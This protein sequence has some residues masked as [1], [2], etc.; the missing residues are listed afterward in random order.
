M[1]RKPK[2]HKG[3]ICRNCDYPLNGEENFGKVSKDY[4]QGKRKRYMNPFQLFL[5]ASIVFFLVLGLINMIETYNNLAVSSEDKEFSNA[6]GLDN[7]VSDD[8]DSFKRTYVMQLD[9]VFEQIKQN[10]EDSLIVIHKEDSIYNRLLMM[11]VNS[12]LPQLDSLEGSEGVADLDISQM[13]SNAVKAGNAQKILDDYLK[14]NNYLVKENV[15]Q[16]ATINYSRVKFFKFQKYSKNHPEV[17]PLV[18][19]DSLKF[20]K[21]KYNIFLYQKG[22][23]FNETFNS[24]EKGLSEFADKIY[25]QTSIALFFLLPVFTLFFWLIYIRSPYSYTEHLIVVFHL[26]SV[27]FILLLLSYLLNFIFN[28]KFFKFIFVLGFF[29]YLY[30]TL[31]NFYNQGRF[32]TLVKLFLMSVVYF[33]I[34]LFGFVAVSFLVFLF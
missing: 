8:V 32:K 15:N 1:A 2:S 33:F 3:I 25:S 21:T 26:Q 29:Y 22:Q 13:T 7:D 16:G 18:A 31:R 24:S 10:P 27:F 11:G 14:D 34:S 4:I 9:S 23:E 19:L 30:K 20:R 5:H 17:K 6:F 12:V 28:V